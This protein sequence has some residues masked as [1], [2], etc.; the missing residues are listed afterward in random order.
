M[1][2]SVR[3]KP[4]AEPGNCTPSQ[5]FNLFWQFIAYAT[6]NK[7]YYNV[8]SLIEELV[9]RNRISKDR[10]MISQTENILMFCEGV[11]DSRLN[12]SATTTV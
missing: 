8:G 9:P 5:Y 1:W 12:D 6:T 11:G 2:G 4:Q 10:E 7:L 3:S